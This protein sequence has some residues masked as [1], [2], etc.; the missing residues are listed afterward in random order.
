MATK[1]NNASK[2]VKVMN[3]LR[4]NASE[5]YKGRVPL[6]TQTNIEQVGNPILN[7]QST[8]NEFLNLIV[9]K[10]AFSIVESRIARNPLSILKKGQVPLGK[11]IE[12]IFV[13][14][15]KAETYDPSGKN[16]LQR[17][18]P[19]VKAVYYRMN[20]QDK[21]KV[22]ISNDQLRTAFTS[23]EEMEKLIAG[24][25]NSLYSGDNYDEFLLMKNLVQS[26]VNQGVVKTEVIGTVNSEETGKNLAKILQTI[27]GLM[28]FPSDEYNTYSNYATK[29]GLTNTS[30]VVTWTPLENQ[31]LLIRADLLAQVN[32]EVLAFAF[33]MSV[34][35]FMMK[36]IKVDK[37]DK[38]GNIQAILCDESFFQVWD[39]MNQMTEFYNG[40]GLYWNYIWHH[41]Q[42]LAV[43]PFANAV[44]F[45]KEAVTEI[46]APTAITAQP[47][48]I[49]LQ[50]GQTKN[51]DLTFTP[52]SGNIDTRV[53]FTSDKPNV[54]SVN[55]ENGRITANSVGTANITIKAV[56]PHTTDPSDSYA[57]A[58]VTV[59]VTE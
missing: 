50:V 13:N 26:A 20:R 8:Q 43:S 14:M 2:M 54:A 59:T 52:T 31:I 4:S 49:T 32:I 36:V 58:T 5:E 10:I 45:V 30:P 56:T 22:T 42:T 51:I 24:I 53:T 21:Y 48:N 38:D 47:A 16:L 46:Q 41:W 29:Q 15:A 25:T 23:W 35:D 40:E 3:V 34:A 37:F 6:A 39:N 33:N 1:S 11:D 27:S 55:N 19:D 9:N 12:S 44:A 7:Y 57:S 17:K 28:E 18:I